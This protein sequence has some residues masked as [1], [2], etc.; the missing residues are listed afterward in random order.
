MN[1]FIKAMASLLVFAFALTAFAQS[2]KQPNLNVLKES[3]FIMG[4]GNAAYPVNDGWKKYVQTMQYADIFD[5]IV[6]EV[7]QI[8]CGPEQN[9]GVLLIG[10]PDNFYKYIFARLASRP[11]SPC[12]EM[13]HVE[14]DINKIEAGHMYVG[15]VDEYWREKIL[16]PSANKNAVLYF[17][18]LGGLI[19]LG[20]HS[21]DDTGIEREYSSNITS[22]KIRTVAF[23]DKFDYNETI[24]SR[25]AYVLESFA[26]KIVLP[27]VTMAQAAAMVQLVLAS[28]YP[29]LKLE[30]KELNYLVKQIQYFMPNRSEPDRSLTVLQRMARAVGDADKVVKTNDVLIETA[31]PYPVSATGTWTIEYPTANEIQ[32]NFEMFDLENNYDLLLVKNANGQILETLTGQKG[33]FRTKFYP[34]NKLILEF[35]ADNSGTNQGFKITS[36]IE[37]RYK[38]H[39]FTLNEVRSAVMTV[40]QVPQWL[41]DR[42][43]SII[44]NL[45]AKLDGDVVGVAEG[46]EDL[47][48]LAKNGYVAGRTDEKPIATIMFAGPTGTGKSYIAKKMAEFT[49]QRLITMDMTSYKDR[50]SFGTFQELM[51]RNLTNS[52]YA[53]YLFEEID[54][55]SIE[56]LDQLYFMMDEGIFY[57]KSQRPL[58]A[59]GS[60]LIFTTNAASDTIL[61]NPKNPELRKLV[62]RDLEAG[63]RAS[64][65]NRFDAISIFLP[66]TAEEYLKLA[67]IMVKKKLGLINEF[68]D[69]NMTADDGVLSYIATYGA[70]AKYGARPMERLVESTIGAG[71]AEYQVEYGAI[72]EQA[73]IALQ[74]LPETH[75]FRIKVNN[76]T[77]DFTVNPSNNGG[78]TAPGPFSPFLGFS[79]ETGI[80]GSVGTQSLPLTEK[81]LSGATSLQKLFEANRMYDDK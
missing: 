38:E 14:V 23:M 22:G 48:R 17:H 42:N 9:K 76:Q 55:A 30:A 54:K 80:G 34:T 56:V 72:P 19:G 41:I 63:F 11:S 71:I 3:G 35:R 20:S 27:P 18:A 67:K 64:F 4:P 8:I 43:Y 68:Y 78:D 77:I 51:T 24:R 65:L 13:W 16:E 12:A 60:F 2:N 69:W 21:N 28:Q 62:M 31:H 6:K 40:A 73:K 66:F 1:K 15:Q 32:L 59:R 58:F 79:A 39:K 29:H 5:G 45:K 70:S 37:A 53:V 33:A 44:K 50:S 49:E 81:A 61:S 47:V 26:T 74:K 75:K 7:E 36:A 10:E 57:D 52:P 25:H 46:K